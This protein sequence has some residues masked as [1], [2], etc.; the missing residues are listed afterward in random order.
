[1]SGRVPRERAVVVAPLKAGRHLLR[2]THL[3]PAARERLS[4]YGD[5]VRG[6]RPERIPDGFFERAEPQH[7]GRA[8]DGRPRSPGE[9]ERECQTQGG[10]NGSAVGRHVRSS[11]ERDDQQFNTVATA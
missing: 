8:A 1:V 6:Y 4:G 3:D 11:S 2:V 5:T 7:W 10:E 9:T